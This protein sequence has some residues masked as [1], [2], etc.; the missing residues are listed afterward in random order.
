MPSK[1]QLSIQDLSSGK[2]NNSSHLDQVAIII[3]T[4]N[5]QNYIARCLQS[6]KEN[7]KN[8][9]IFL[10]DNDSKDETL[11]I[12]RRET[13]HTNIE[14]FEGVANLGFGKANNACLNEALN[15]DFQCFFLVNHDVYVTKGLLKELTILHKY[16]IENGR[17]SILC[18]VQL[19]GEG[20][21]IDR[22]FSMYLREC[23]VPECN[24]DT[25]KALR[26]VVRGQFFNAAAW[27]MGREIVEEVGGFNPLFEH[28]GEDNDF[29]N[30]ALAKG[31]DFDCPLWLNVHHDR[32][33]EPAALISRDY[34]YQR[35]RRYATLLQKAT[36]PQA[37]L[38][39]LILSESINQTRNCLGQLRRGRWIT[40]LAIT[41][42]TFKLLFSIP[43]IIESR[44]TTKD[45]RRPFL[46][47][48]NNKS[49]ERLNKQNPSRVLAQ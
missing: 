44:S 28:Y 6:I 20:D 34:G 43:A 3:V 36:Q 31:V 29:A 42:A 11:Q 13:E 32:E 48:T 22:N 18:P 5:S 27:F 30:R 21:R 12:V 41:M 23:N 10:Y 26:T 35:M 17:R 39:T 15:Q 40:A 14:T 46:A 1:P 19:D 4:Y 49:K 33:Q 8:Y 47:S 25:L 45:S 16:T 37:N 38:T 7:C 24:V 9:K 2:P